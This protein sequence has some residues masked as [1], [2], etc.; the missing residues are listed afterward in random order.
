MHRSLILLILLLPA[1]VSAEAMLTWDAP[2]AGLTPEGY[3]VFYKDISASDW[4]SAVDV[5]NVTIVSLRDLGIVA[6][7][8]NATYIFGAKS[9]RISDN[10]TS[11]MSD[12]SDPYILAGVPVPT[13]FNFFIM[14]S[15]DVP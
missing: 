13:P 15:S 9:Y 14:E 8:D 2:D 7:R 4:E 1:I 12:L 5:G 3:R 6:Q 11:F 10:R